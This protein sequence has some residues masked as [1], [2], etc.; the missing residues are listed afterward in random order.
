MALVRSRRGLVDSFSSTKEYD[1]PARGRRGAQR[2]QAPSGAKVFVTPLPQFHL[3]SKRHRGNS[4]FSLHRILVIEYVTN[5]SQNYM[6][7][8]DG[9]SH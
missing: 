2:R 8:G 5:L 1:A 7:H 6:Q 9:I 3:K 4:E